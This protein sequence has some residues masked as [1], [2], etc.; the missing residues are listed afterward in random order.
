MRTSVAIDERRDTPTLTVVRKAPSVQ[1]SMRKDTDLVALA[2]GGD[3]RAFDE[4]VTRYRQR[5]YRLSYKILRNEDDA[6]EAM[7]ETF[8]SAYRGIA[9]F[10]HKSTFSTWLYRIATNAALMRVRRRRDNIV[11]LDQPQHDGETHEPMAIPD[12][13]RQPLQELL[14]AE[15]REV[16]EEG[17]RL[18]PE[19]LRAV[20]VLRVLEE[21]PNDEVGNILSLTG[22]AVK[23]R[24]HRARLLLRDRLHRHFTDRS[25]RWEPQPA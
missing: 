10:Q 3:T 18:L 19:R 9:R 13:S 7:Q 8:L 11:S 5:V 14:D 16:M 25:P 23:S 12:W 22:A 24:L 21:I 1:H 6:A 15:T 2:Q 20:F 4:L 17:I